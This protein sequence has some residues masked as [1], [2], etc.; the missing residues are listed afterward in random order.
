MDWAVT[1]PP[2][3]SLC[4]AKDEKDNECFCREKGKNPGSESLLITSSGIVS[5]TGVTVLN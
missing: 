4:E 2:R 3:P 1:P 5:I